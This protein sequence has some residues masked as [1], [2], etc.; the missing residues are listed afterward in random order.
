M[1]KKRLLKRNLHYNYDGH[2]STIFTCVQTKFKAL[3]FMASPN[4][5][6]LRG[7]SIILTTHRPK[8]TGEAENANSENIC[9]QT[10]HL[11]NMGDP[12]TFYVIQ[13]SKH[14]SSSFDFHSSEYTFLC[15][16]LLCLHISTIRKS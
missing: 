11:S 13:Q 10:G 9:F 6:T 8:K 1:C 4:E 15:F 14:G 5:A 7:R 2:A 16:R 3:W 12:L